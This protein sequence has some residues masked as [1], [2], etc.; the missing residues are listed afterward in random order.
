MQKIIVRSDYLVEMGE[1]LVS[2]HRCSTY[3]IEAEKEEKT[4]GGSGVSHVGLEGLQLAFYQIAQ[5]L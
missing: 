3:Q 4:A 2:Q 5:Q 1:G